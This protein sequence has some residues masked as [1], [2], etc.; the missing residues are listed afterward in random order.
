[1]AVTRFSSRIV[2]EFIGHLPSDHL[3][4]RS[5][6]LTLLFI[7]R[8]RFKLMFF[9]RLPVSVWIMY[10]IVDNLIRPHLVAHSASHAFMALQSF[11]HFPS[12]A[13]QI[14]YSHYFAVVPWIRLRPIC[15]QPPLQI[16]SL[17]GRPYPRALRCALRTP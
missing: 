2:D 3:I 10:A 7:A 17:G 9:L 14:Q 8:T 13:M 16:V 5:C 1:M 12:P 11:L 6:T 15:D 4:L